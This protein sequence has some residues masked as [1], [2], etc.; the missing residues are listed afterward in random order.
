MRIRFSIV[1]AIATLWFAVPALA[2]SDLP[3]SAMQMPMPPGQQH[4]TMSMPKN[5]LDIDH[6]RDGSGT[7]WLPD[8]SPMHALMHQAGSW[9]LML[10]GNG[11]LQFLKSGSSR[12]DQQVGSVNWI[13]LMA[14]R[15]LYGGQFVLH[16]MLSA[17]PATVGR[18]GYPALLQSGE[19]CRGTPLHDRQHPH[20]LFMELAA[21]YRRAINDRVAIELYGGP[22]GEPALGPTSYPH[23]LSAMPNLYA[24]ITHHWL[25]SSHISFGVMTGGMYG[26][27]WKAEASI[28]NGR[29]P[30]DGRYN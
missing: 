28:F 1:S 18:C 3:Q 15:T 5:P 17:E 22:A 10:H 13:M 30:D 2:Q 11:F 7:S 4:Q 16:A 12:G 9:M 24:P 14:Q 20:D 26:R 29:E 6:V 23:R 19:S 21:D 25:D 8:D 27:R